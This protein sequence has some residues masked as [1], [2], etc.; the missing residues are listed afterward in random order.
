MGHL[1]SVII[2]TYNRAHILSRAIESVLAQTYQHWELIIVDD[3]STD[4]TATVVAAYTDPR[5]RFIHQENKGPSA[6]RN[7]GIHT[8][9]GDLICYLDSD[10]EFLPIYMETM[11]KVFNDSSSVVFAWTQ[12]YRTLTALKGGEVVATKDDNENVAKD[13][14]V[15]DIFMR[16]YYFTTD[17]LI[18]TRAIIEKNIH[19]DESLRTSEDWDF[20]MQIGEVFTEQF[21]YNTTPLFIYHRTVGGDSLSFGID[22][23]EMA[24]TFEYIYQ[25]HKND[26]MLVGQSWYPGRVDKYTML[27][28]AYRNGTALPPAEFWG[29]E[30]LKGK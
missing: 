24:N 12:Y 19:W 1:I 9:Q 15:K 6:A 30:L 7:K 2:P 4:S 25:K 11:A 10:D 8:A 18:H 17:G 21:F 23:K 13:L 5:I 20:F 3:G 26:R 14:T 28:E 27:D 22:Y 16:E 29:G